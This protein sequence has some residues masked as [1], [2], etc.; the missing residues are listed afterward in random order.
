VADPAKNRIVMVLGPADGAPYRSFASLAAGR[1]KDA[2][3][4][5]SP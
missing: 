2:P 4:V 3:P 5:A 1:G